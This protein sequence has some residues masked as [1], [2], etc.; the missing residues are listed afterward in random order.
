MALHVVH[1]A[2]MALLQHALCP[3]H[4]HLQN[5]SQLKDKTFGDF[6]GKSLQFPLGSTVRPMKRCLAFQASCAIRDAIA[7]EYIKEE[8]LLGKNFLRMGGSPAVSKVQV[9]LPARSD[10]Q[11]L[12][13]WGAARDTGP[14]SLPA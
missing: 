4:P 12:H 8:W 5:F 7:R 13:N 14:G 11:W 9:S 1:V 10:I 6:S 2:V 3:A